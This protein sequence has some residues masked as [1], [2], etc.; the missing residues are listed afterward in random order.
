MA[1]GGGQ[2]TVTAGA[3]TLT[4][5]LSLPA[6]IFCKEITLQVPTGGVIAYAGGANVTAV[7]ANARAECSPGV[8]VQ[9]LKEGMGGL[10]NTD[11]VYLI[12]AGGQIFISLVS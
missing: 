10:I 2:A 5:L 3:Q 12:G 6:R 11:E 7:P 8:Q 9:I 4:A 1:W